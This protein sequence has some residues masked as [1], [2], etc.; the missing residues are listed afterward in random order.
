MKNFLQLA[1]GL[2]VTPLLSALQRQPELW[3]A[4]PIRT[5]HPGT[6]HSEV[7]DILCRFN[8]IAEFE[9]TGDPTTIT[10]DKECIAY[11]AWEKLP[12][13]RPIIFDLMRTVEAVRLGRVIITKLPPGKSIT[14]HVDG[15]APAEY[16]ERYMVALQCLPGS[17]FYIGDEAVT[18][19]AGDVF[20]INNKIEHWVQNHS[21][22][23]RLVLIIDCRCD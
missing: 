8:D 11:P 6:A 4:H 18:F 21:A 23:D 15:G 3:N 9:R 7:S 5:K 22:D 13:L 16:F 12:Q 20:H 14:P 2:N 19:R 1:A 17:V 10:D